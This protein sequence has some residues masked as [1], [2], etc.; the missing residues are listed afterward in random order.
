MVVAQIVRVFGMTRVRKLAAAVL[1]VMGLLSYGMMFQGSR[2]LWERD[3]GR[4]TNIAVRMLRTGDFVV[5]AFNDD[6]PHFTKP[7]LTYWAIAGGITLLGWNEW[8]ARLPNALAFTGTVLLVFA[9]ARRI[10]PGR[11]WLPPVVYATSLFPFIAANFVTTDTLLTLWE[12]VAVLGFVYW[13]D[14][15]DRT[16]GAAFLLMMWA[17]FGLAFLTKGPPG[18]LPLQAI[19]VFVVL[20]EGWRS[21]LRLFSFTGLVT[22]AAIGL[23][24][25]L[26]VAATHPGLA[27]YFV[28]DELVLRFASGMH[29]RNPEWYKGFIIYVP[30]LLLG[31]LPWT[32]R[33]VPAARSIPK[34]L[35][36]FVWWRNKL[37]GDQWAVFLI[38]WVFLPLAVFFVSKSRL[39]LYI[40]PLFVPIALMTGRWT[41]LPSR[42]KAGVFLLAAWIVV[43]IA[44]KFAGAL[45]PYTKDSRAMAQ[46]IARSVQPAPSEIVF[47]DSDPFW[48]LSLY[49]RCEAERVVTSSHAQS[50]ADETLAEEL[51]EGEPRVLFV[52]D[53]NK[54]HEVIETCRSLGYPVRRVGHRGSWVFIAL[55]EAFGGLLDLPASESDTR[56][57]AHQP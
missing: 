29:G 22:F 12:T 25:Y 26:V 35:F 49:L 57:A 48:G 11:P 9:I 18:L 10:T 2:G 16:Q 27:T 5:P 17:G 47:I 45:F 24:W 56:E 55:P 20:A 8:G 38:L 44:L 39:P 3:E 28:H 34:S 53:K 52:A 19:L 14:R 51:K 1:L 7:P 54:E 4:Y 21:G 43:L 41:I 50:P 33:L 36:S 32:F 37:K 40:L 6:V 31:T 13:W 46:S 42:P 23:G 15:K 30:V